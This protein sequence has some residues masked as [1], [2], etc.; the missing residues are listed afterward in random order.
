MCFVPYIY[1]YYRSGSVKKLDSGHF[2]IP[3][4][5]YTWVA[6][7][8]EILKYLPR[9]MVVAYC[10]VIPLPRNAPPPE[11]QP[12]TGSFSLSYSV[13]LKG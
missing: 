8:E 12:P 13:L 11:I 10:T 2:D 7:S 6:E 5:K 9:R 4:W 3:V 1:K